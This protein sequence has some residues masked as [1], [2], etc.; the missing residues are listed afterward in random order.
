VIT[1]TLAVL[2]DA[3]PA[4]ERLA[5]QPLPVKVAYAVAKLARLVRPEVE[6]FIQ[7][8]NELVRA[9]GAPANGTIEVRPE[10]RDV[11]VAKVVE[12]ASVEVTI[13]AAP[14]PLAALDGV[15]VMAHDLMALQ[16][17]VI[18]PPTPTP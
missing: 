5:A 17:F 13:D 11:Y 15:R 16:A 18:D 4:L 3:Q 8:R 2:V 6:H 1:T 10:E 7:Q 14:I 9:H 12:L